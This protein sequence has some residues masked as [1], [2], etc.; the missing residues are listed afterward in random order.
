LLV[1]A[2]KNNPVKCKGGHRTRPKTK[3]KEMKNMQ[4]ARSLV[5]VE[6]ER[7]SCSLVAIANFACEKT[8]KIKRHEFNAQKTVF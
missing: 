7:E 1:R 8:Y 5:T 4:N 2:T 3:T 6:R